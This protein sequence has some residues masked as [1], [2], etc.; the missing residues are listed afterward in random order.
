MKVV[1]L[2]DERIIRRGLEKI[3]CENFPFVNV[4]ASLGDGQE[5][6]DFFMDH[7]VD[8]LITDIR[9][10]HF[11]GL[12]IIKML[13]ERKVDIDVIVISGYDDFQYCKEAL[14]YQAFEYILKPIDKAEFINI[15]KRFIERK[16]INETKGLEEISDREKKIIRD[17]KFYLKRNYMDSVN[18]KL[19]AEQFH[20]NAVYISQL[21]KKETGE[22]LTEYLLKIRMEKAAVLLGDT[23]LRIQEISDMVGYHTTKQFSAIFKRYYGV[24]PSEYRNNII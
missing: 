14:K 9:M 12:A 20:L 2:D 8:L 15:I 6:M 5:A 18:L 4:I 3:L 10:P 17:I 7:Q 16:N 21:F 22:S 19:L 24:I 23:N 13:R 11:D 1:L